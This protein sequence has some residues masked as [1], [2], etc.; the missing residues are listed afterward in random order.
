MPKENLDVLGMSDEDFQKLNAPPVF[1]K[2]DP[3]ET[4]ELETEEEFQEED[5]QEDDQDDEE[6]SEPAEHEEG[7][8]EETEEGVIPTPTPDPTP[9]HTPDPEPSPQFKEDTEEKVKP[10]EPDYKAFYQAVMAPFKANGKMIELK[11]PEEAIKLMQM[12]ANYT[13][14]MQA[15]QPYRK[16]LLMLEN[17]NLLDEDK[18]AFLIDVEKKNPEAIKKLLKDANIDPYDIDTTEEPKY[19]PGAHV[20]SDQEV[21]YRTALD[22]LSAL[23]GG[24]ETL[25]V[26]NEWDRTSKEYLWENP[27]L[28]HL[29]HTQ[30]EN[31]VYD[32]VSLEIDRRITLGQISPQTPFLVVYKEVGDQLAAEGAFDNLA[33]KANP[34]REPVASKVRRK[35][36][37]NDKA[38]AAAPP[39][40]TKKKAEPIINPLSLDD[41]EFLKQMQNRV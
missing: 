6:S 26:L 29:I 37:R 34:P 41:D 27:E 5:S 18:L 13:K 2:E 1:S 40:S 36:V 3:E 38:K 9:T 24:R 19:T 30:R 39:R 10:E 8:E 4:E 12:G 15:I 25:R 16:Y 31:G 33:A 28:F 23:P 32:L 22:E 20:V 21:A 7:D 11:S 35:S 14:K 17:N